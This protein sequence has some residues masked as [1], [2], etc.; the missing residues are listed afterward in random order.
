V[1]RKYVAWTVRGCDGAARLR[2][3]V[4]TLTSRAEL[5]ALLDDAGAA[6]LGP[7]GWFRPVFSSGEG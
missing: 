7:Q 4:Q 1:G 6:G 5:D 2:A 3:R